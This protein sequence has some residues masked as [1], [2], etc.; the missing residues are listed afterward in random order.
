MLPAEEQK[1]WRQWVNQVPVIGFNSGKYDLNIAKAYFEK[2][3]SYN[4]EDECNE[5]VFAAK[6]ENDYMSFT[7]SRFKFVN[8]KNYIGPDLS[9]DRWC[10]SMCC[11]LQ[12]L[13]FPYEW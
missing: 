3:I 9:Y 12:K 8:V 7:T 4:K 10:K 1:Q 5:D 11:G 2:K 6:K 13:M